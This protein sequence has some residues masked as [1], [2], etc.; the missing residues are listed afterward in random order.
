MLLALN[1]DLGPACERPVEVIKSVVHKHHT[2][3]RNVF[4]NRRLQQ[5]TSAHSRRTEQNDKQ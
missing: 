1:Q 5:G 4:L 2:V 3:K